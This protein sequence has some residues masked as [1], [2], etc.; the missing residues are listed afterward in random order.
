M[1]AT[2]D[3]SFKLKLKLKLKVALSNKQMAKW[4]R[5]QT[6]CVDS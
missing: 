3:K 4:R 5:A 1:P 2:V 6:A